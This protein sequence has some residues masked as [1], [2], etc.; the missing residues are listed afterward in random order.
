MLG[1]SARQSVSG[2][3]AARHRGLSAH[4]R[5]A[6]RRARQVGA[7]PR[8]RD[9]GRQADPA[10]HPE[11]CSPGRPDAGRYLFRRHDRHGAAA[12]EAARRHG[13]GAGRGRPARAHRASPRIPSSSRPMRRSWRRGRRRARARRAGAH[14]GRPVR[15]VHQAQQEDPARGAGLDQPDRRSQQAGRHRWPRTSR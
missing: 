1:T 14:G 8:R 9:E 11:E 5:A 2:P 7:R 15:A 3:A 4:D 12:A 6:L 10:G 13:E